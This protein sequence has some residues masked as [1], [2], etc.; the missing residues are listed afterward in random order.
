[1]AQGFVIDPTQERTFW[2]KVLV[3]DVD[4]NGNVTKTEIK[5]RFVWR[6]GDDID[7][8]AEEAAKDL[9]QLV[10]AAETEKDPVV[11]GAK[12]AI[13][14]GPTK[15]SDRVED[16][17][18]IARDWEFVEIGGDK[19]FHAETVHHFLWLVPLA[20]GAIRQT[21][22]VLMDGEDPKKVIWEKQRGSR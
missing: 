7:E 8:T 5:V 15:L 13:A 12:L 18:S 1:M 6:T 10:D 3:P 22:N 11:R 17:L 9:K 19:S 2:H 21:Y 20:Y 4:K 14:K 16:V